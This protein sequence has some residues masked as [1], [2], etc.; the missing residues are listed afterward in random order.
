MSLYPEFARPTS[1]AQAAQLLAGL[2]SGSAVIAGG[3][4]LMPSINYGVLMP[5]VYVDINGLKELKGIR[6]DDGWLSI[7]A[8]TVHR[9]LQSDPLVRT[10]A[11]LLA[12]SA[13]RAG[14][15]RQV[16]NRATLG[17]NLV[18]MHPLYDIAPALLALEA[19]V[20]T[21]K[22]ETV[23]RTSLAKLMADT[24]HGLGSEA[25]LIRV[26]IRPIVA[27]TGTA[28]EKLKLSGGAYGSANAA[29]IVTL[30]GGRIA[31]LQLVLGAVSE[32]LIDA[33]HA[34][35]FCVG[36]SWSA[37]LGEQL[38][39]RCTELV[40]TP[41]SDQQGDGAWRQA[42]AGVVARRAVSAAIDAAKAGL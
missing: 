39:A 25:I 1:L 18:A 34:A 35:S 8:L 5:S 14:G 17:G 30:D 37:E 31:R 24:G 22:G 4:E 10:H 16:H 13:A 28:Y 11:P 21:I 29:A 12:A 6:E 33:S 7:G 40:K 27:G 32:R 15:G 23:Q 41:L 9:E 2:S 3:Q 19:E 38:A 42:M 26:L 20:E 36:Q